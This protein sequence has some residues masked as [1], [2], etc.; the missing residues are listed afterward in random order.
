MVSEP[1]TVVLTLTHLQ[2]ALSIPA[3]YPPDI[4]GRICSS[5]VLAAPL[6]MEGL[7]GRRITAQLVCRS[8]RDATLAEH[9]IWAALY[10]DDHIR[11]CDLADCL[12]LSGTVPLTIHIELQE[13][14]RRK[15]GQLDARGTLALALD[16]LRPQLHRCTHLVLQSH[17][18]SATATL[19]DTLRTAN[20]PLL[21]SLHLQLEPPIDDGSSRPMMSVL[22]PHL[23]LLVATK[24]L[25]GK[26]AHTLLNGIN[27]LRLFDIVH[28]EWPAYQ[29]TFSLASHITH[30]HLHCVLCS[31]YNTLFAEPTG[32]VVLPSVTHLSMAIVDDHSGR[33]LNLLRFPAVLSVVLDIM[34]SHGI[35]FYF[36]RGF[37][38]FRR[39]RDVT[40]LLPQGYL[41]DF[42][43]MFSAMPLLQNLDV[44][45]CRCD[46]ASLFTSSMSSPASLS[47]V[48]LP[49]DLPL[50]LVARLEEGR[51]Y[52]GC[53]WKVASDASTVTCWTRGIW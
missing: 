24:W 13:F 15:P 32:V 39:A 37:S 35:G 46:Y 33:L 2:A 53:E 40:L 5:F 4:I 1:F 19:L 14:Y 30:L 27:T 41:L 38:L 42:A 50:D 31:S 51:L 28:E 25:P 45:G 9:A 12:N 21:R 6:D 48:V 34:Y 44:G 23:T 16:T 29:L 11:T 17:T 43:S 10:V 8:W 18:P 7:D 3:N 26:S 36:Q 47:S 49:G 52:P 20:F 22:P